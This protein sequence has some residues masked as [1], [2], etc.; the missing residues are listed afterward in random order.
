MNKLQENLKQN[1]IIFFQ[2]NTF[3]KWQQFCWSSDILQRK[4]KVFV[5]MSTAGKGWNKECNMDEFIWNIS[6][7]TNTEREMPLFLWNFCHW[8]HRKL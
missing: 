4:P 1:T 7:I 6:Y 3:V 2:E 8:L 5:Q